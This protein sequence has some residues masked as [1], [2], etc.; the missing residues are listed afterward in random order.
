M[1]FMLLIYGNE[2]VEAKRKPA[3]NAAIFGAY[4]SYGKAMRDAGAYVDGAPLLPSKTARTVQVRK[5]RS[6]KRAGPAFDTKDSLGGYYIIEA[7]SMADAVKWAAKC[8]G[9][10]DGSIEVRPLMAMG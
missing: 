4:M 3:E 10:L 7:K 5:S 1:K 8:P 9:A 6:A 2:R